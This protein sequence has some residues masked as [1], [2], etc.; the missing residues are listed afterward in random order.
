[1]NSYISY[2]IH[3]YAHNIQMCVYTQNFFWK[4]TFSAAFYIIGSIDITL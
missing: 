3:T 4:T 1:M 2:T